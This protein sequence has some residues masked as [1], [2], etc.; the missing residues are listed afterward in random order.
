MQRSNPNFFSN[1]LRVFAGNAVA[2]A[3]TFISMPII[4]RLYA[5]SDFGQA[6][7]VISI[8][9]VVTSIASLRYDAAIVV[10]STPEMVRILFV[11]SLLICC[12]VSFLTLITLSIVAQVTTHP[13]Y[14]M[15]DFLLLLPTLVLIMGTSQIILF[16]FTK[17]SKFSP[18]AKFNIGSSF[19][20]QSYRILAG[21]SGFSNGFS[22]VSA[23]VI[24]QLGAILCS[25][26]NI[27]VM[28]K[29]VFSEK[30]RSRDL[31]SG[32]KRY[33][34]FPIYSSWSYLMNIFAFQMP[35]I[36]FAHFFDLEHVGF[37]SMAVM[38]LSS[39][40]IM[41]N[42][43]SR[44]LYQ[45][46]AEAKQSGHLID[47]IW[48]VYMKLIVYTSPPFLMV[49]MYGRVL[50]RLLFGVQW[51]TSGVYCQ[52]LA[53]LYFT[54]FFTASLGSLY[55]VTERQKENSFFI[56]GRV[57]LQCCGLVIGGKAG[58]LIFALSAYALVGM[59]IR[60]ASIFWIMA[61]VGIPV[62]KSLRLLGQ[63][64]LLAGLPLLIWKT[65]MHFADLTPE[66]EV[67]AAAMTFGPY[68][69]YF[70]QR[71]HSRGL[72]KRFKSNA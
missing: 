29:F 66:I 4:S 38:A 33:K 42:A 21:V 55:N 49:A 51:D 67:V 14:R 57:V 47:L 10:A 50:L 27:S 72:F 53:P 12:L 61:H 13:A 8:A 24:G 54:I 52:I 62:Q 46:S 19:F 20:Q 35:V 48:S 16:M 2:S 32:F 15:E 1:I 18:I 41:A 26:K 40:K 25:I 37:Y 3:I 69:Y 59:I 56:M 70:L 68:Y 60:S 63:S 28:T 17:E 6:S 31:V 23:I 43:I 64:L 58:N 71:D 44:V 36:M 7:Y 11:I 65:S 9:T 30:I 45:M 39:A 34:N 22:Y 5:P